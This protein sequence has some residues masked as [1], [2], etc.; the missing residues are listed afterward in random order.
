MLNEEIRNSE[1]Y[2]TFLAY[3]TGIIPL[4]TGRDPDEALKLEKSISKTEA[5]IA[6]EERKVHATHECLVTEKPTN[7]DDEDE[8]RLI[9]RRPTSVVL[10]D[11]PT[12]SKK[13]SLDQS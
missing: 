2:Q 13:K 3:S 7:N 6:K 11:T 1:G 5:K 10:R 12:V 4:K 8:V 9:R